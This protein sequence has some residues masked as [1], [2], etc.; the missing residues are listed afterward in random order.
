MEHAREK[1]AR[2]GLALIAANDITAT[3][4]GFGTD[5]NRVVLIDGDGNVE[6]LPLLTKYDTAQRLLDRLST[7]LRAPR[8]VVASDPLTAV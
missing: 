3:D 6:S 5:T 1:L 2:K 4:A 7:L 8:V